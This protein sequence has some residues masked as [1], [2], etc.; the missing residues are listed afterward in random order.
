MRVSLVM[1][2]KRINVKKSRGYSQLLTHAISSAYS[3]LSSFSLDY[4]S[5]SSSW[6]SASKKGLL[7]GCP[8]YYSCRIYRKLTWRMNF[9]PARFFLTLLN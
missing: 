6:S 9:P 7:F 5:S 4:Y 1:T 2:V 3:F 8:P